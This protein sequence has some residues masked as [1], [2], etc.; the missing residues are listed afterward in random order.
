MPWLTLL[1]YIEKYISVQ[2]GSPEIHCADKVI[3][4]RKDRNYLYTSVLYNTSK[5]RVSNG[6]RMR[7]FDKLLEVQFPK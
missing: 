3:L 5:E 4:V 1:N 2:I 6:D 7:S